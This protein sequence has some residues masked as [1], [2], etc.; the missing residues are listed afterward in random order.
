VLTSLSQKSRTPVPIYGR[1]DT[2][3]GSLLRFPHAASCVLALALIATPNAQAAPQAR[4]ATT[5]AVTPEAKAVET[6]A[7]IRQL[8]VEIERETA[9][10]E[11]ERR[12]FNELKSM[13][14][15]EALAQVVLGEKLSAAT[16]PQRAA[17][18][19]ALSDL[20]ADN[21]VERL[22]G[23]HAE[24]FE[25]GA[26]RTLDNRDVV[27]VSHVKFR[28]GH[29]GELDWRMH[30]KGPGQV[31]AQVMADVLVDGASVAIGARDQASGELASNGGS[32]PALIASMRN[33][34]RFK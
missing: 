17:F 27:V 2:E 31:T 12:K 21:L 30:A 16:A 28:D 11:V 20:V 4:A 3:K 15:G 33:R 32:I 22:G 19:S 5:Q 10:R 8:S 13:I 24:P 34:L 26:A 25:L 9:P 14:D 1:I 7:R 6:V 18:I 23:P 29:R